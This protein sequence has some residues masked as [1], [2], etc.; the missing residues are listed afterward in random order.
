MDGEELIIDA[1]TE[2][3]EV[4]ETSVETDAPEIST[5]VPETPAGETPEG[6]EGD[7]RNLP[8]DVQKFLKSARENP[9]TAKVARALNDA[10]FREQ[11]YS[12][13][14]KPAEI[15]AAAATLSRLGGDEGIAQMEQQLESMRLVD[16]DIAKG[17]PGFLDDI[18]KTSPDG[19]KKLAPHVLNKLFTLDKVAYGNAVAPVIAGTLKNYQIPQILSTLQASQDPAAKAA[20]EALSGLT[21]DLEETLRNVPRAEDNSEKQKTQGEWDKIN[22]EKHKMELGSVGSETVKHQSGLVDKNLAPLLKQKPLQPEAK[23]DLKGGIN[24]EIQKLLVE[25]KNYQQ[26]VKAAVDKIK[27]NVAS[28]ANTAELKRSLASYVNAKMD[29]VAPKAVKSVWNRRY[30]ATPTVKPPANGQPQARNGVKPKMSEVD[31]VPN[32]ETLYIA[33]KAYIKGKLVNW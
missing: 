32:W 2:T 18:I 22:N 29:E 24:Q 20:F 8:K 27:Q 30:G 11:A 12:K 26:H 17:D 33:H 9:E 10:Y 28:G 25:D 31:R 21:K 16:A 14:G 13:Y 6:A 23:A 5:D 7:A 3:G 1:G 4:V 15:A 19:F